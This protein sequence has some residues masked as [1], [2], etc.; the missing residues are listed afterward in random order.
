MWSLTLDAKGK[1]KD[2][3][4]GAADWLAFPSTSCHRGR[5]SYS[6]R[7]SSMMSMQNKIRQE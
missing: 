4:G 6:R 1:E 5:E 7:G 3:F 2:P